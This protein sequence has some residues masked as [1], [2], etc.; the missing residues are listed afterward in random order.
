[1]IFNS[2]RVTENQRDLENL[3]QS[4]P[5]FEFDADAAME[6]GKLR[7]ELKRAGRPIPAVDSMIA[8]IARVR[9]ATVLSADKHFHEV[10]GL[11][12]QSWL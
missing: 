2:G 5:V 12:I 6:Y 1:M 8:A 3:L 7:T 4:L 11:N 10:A 9:G